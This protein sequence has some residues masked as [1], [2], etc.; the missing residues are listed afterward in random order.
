MNLS[1]YFLD[2]TLANPRIAD[3]HDRT[4]EGQDLY[5]YHFPAESLKEVVFGI[6]MDFGQRRRIAKLIND[7]YEGVQL[8]EAELSK[9]QFDLDIVPYET[10][11]DPI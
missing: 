3:R 2:T 9:E 1:S 7:K 6:R 8:L 10:R 11:F 4:P 5:L